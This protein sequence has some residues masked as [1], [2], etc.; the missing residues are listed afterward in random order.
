[1]GKDYYAIL[2]VARD[3]TDAQIK[4]AYRKMAMRWH[5]DKNPNDK[6]NATK[7]FKEVSEA[8]EVLSD[9]EKRGIYDKFGEEGLKGTAGGANAQTFSPEEMAHMFGGF[10][11][12]GKSSFFHASDPFEIFSQFFGGSNPFGV[13]IGFG[14]M[15]GMD[16]RS[17]RPRRSAPTKCT[18]IQHTLMLTLEEL[19]KGTTKKV[20]VTRTRLVSEGSNAV[21]DEAKIF[22]VPIKAG[23]K[24]GTKITYEGDGEQR[25][26]YIPGDVVFIVG[27]KPHTRF[28]RDG[29]DLIT[30]LRVPLK[31]ALCGFTTRVDTLDGR[32]LHVNINDVIRPGYV[33]IVENEGMPISKQPGKKGNLRIEFTIDFPT[34]LSD[35]KKAALRNIL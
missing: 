8:Y 25:P 13:D 18:P 19:Y 33:K 6:E 9:K 28:A 29:N 2:G 16:Q 34:Y 21:R 35:E 30:K 1:M 15:P 32:A 31:E 14:S 11:G 24:P 4:T 22:E 27:E 17:Y 10:G 26:G 20:R 12:G 3:A 23:Y 5:P 7:H